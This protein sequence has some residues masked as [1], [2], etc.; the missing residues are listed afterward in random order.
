MMW[1]I[2]K[3]VND[4]NQYGDYFEVAFEH[5]PTLSELSLYLY[6]HGKL[7]DLDDYQLMDV[8]HL[9]RGG[10]RKDLENEWYNLHG[11]K[12]GEKLKY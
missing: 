5:S 9:K 1:I 10:G 12:S 6:G 4:Y 11:L 7:E 8:T 2:T 3:S